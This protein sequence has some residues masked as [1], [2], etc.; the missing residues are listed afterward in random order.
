MIHKPAKNETEAVQIFAQLA[1][2][3]EVNLVTPVTAISKLPEWTQVAFSRVDVDASEDSGDVY[4]DRR[5]C[6]GDERALTK[7]AILRLMQAAGINKISS[8]QVDSEGHPYFCQ[9]A[10]RLAW[11]DFT[12]A[13]RVAEIS[14]TIDLRDGAPLTMKPERVCRKHSSATCRACQWGDFDKTGRSVPLD[15]TALGAARTHLHAQAETKALLRGV[16][17]ALS[18]KQ[19]YKAKDLE[20]P[21]VVP[22]LVADLPMDD[23]QVKAAVLERE[24]GTSES[25]Y[26]GDRKPGLV[27]AVLRHDDK[28]RGI[29]RA[30]GEEIEVPEAEVVKI[31]ADVSPL[32]GDE[33]VIEAES[34][35]SGP[36][37]PEPP[38]LGEEAGGPSGR[39]RG[40]ESS[41]TPASPA[42]ASD[43]GSPEPELEVAPADAC[44]CPCGCEVV[45]P[46]PQI[47]KSRGRLGVVRCRRCYPD[48][49][50]DAVAHEGVGSLELPEFPNW[51]PATVATKNK[52]RG[53][54]S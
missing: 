38:S 26:G 7:N 16:R 54:S 33:R 5:F 53:G 11:R 8:Q 34:E 32:P 27:G 12:G 2:S 37:G 49:N 41:A 52:R 45:P 43:S 22:Q 3:G 25:I 4:V 29:K 18:L 14:K 17:E 10:V 21:F 28:A 48:L 46:K 24:L 6:K 9:W 19:K 47:A 30:R 23:P 50:F 51:T 42:P 44:N 40:E 36:M 1:D 35:G 31:D 39:L 15:E 20:R 13:H